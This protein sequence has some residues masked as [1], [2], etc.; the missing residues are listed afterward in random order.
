MP[1]SPHCLPADSRPRPQRIT[2]IGPA[3]PY[4]GGAAQHTTELAHRLAAAG[5]TVA[6]ESWRAQYPALLYPGQLTIDEPELP[7][8]SPT[9]RTLSWRSPA[10]WVRQSRRMGAASDVVILQCHAIVQYL[11]YL[12]M[13]R[14]LRR[15]GA[16]VVL[17]VNNVLPH[18]ARSVDRRVAQALYRRADALLVHGAEQAALARELTDTPVRTAALPAHLPATSI[19]AGSPGD[20]G[21]PNA[22]GAERTNS[23]LFF[24]LVR[25]YKGLDVLLRALAKA[26]VTASLVVS[27]EFW[28][29]TG[30]TEE[31]VDSLGLTARVALRPGYV[32]AAEIPAL[33]ARC[34]ALVLPYR[35]AT[36]SQNALLAFEHA[37]PVIVTRTGTLADPVTDGVDGIVC[38]ADDVDDLVGA[39]ERFYAPGEAERLRANVTRPDPGPAWDRYIAELVRR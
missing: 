18:E 39:L 15:R 2:V 10:G 12:A 17:I 25:P 29:G 9:R 1:G 3:H 6:L 35:A 30:A 24:G 32:D 4:K 22:D 21:A 36:G 33:F 26:D 37:R 16:R 13:M 20:A 23:L 14:G 7:V 5:H 19:P 11:P 34:D 31:L 8:F 27:G 38:Q 28:G